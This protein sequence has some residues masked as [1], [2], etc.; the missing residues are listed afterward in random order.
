MGDHH[1]LLGHSGAQECFSRHSEIT[2]VKTNRF[3]P[4]FLPSF[5]DIKEI[6]FHIYSENC[7][8]CLLI[9]IDFLLPSK[10]LFKAYVKWLDGDGLAQNLI[11]GPWIIEQ[12]LHAILV[13]LGSFCEFLWVCG[14]RGAGNTPDAQT[15]ASL[16]LFPLYNTVS[17]LGNTFSPL[18]LEITIKLKQLGCFQ[19]CRWANPRLRHSCSCLVGERAILWAATWCILWLHR[20]PL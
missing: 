5:H 10:K 16:L 3:L 17:L 18:L 6:I 1:D 20:T 4:H 12:C 14:H 11:W 2:L 15:Q 9:L 19:Q 8:D 13:F 7:N